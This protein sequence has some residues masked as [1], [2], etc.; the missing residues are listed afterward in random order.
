M[1]KYVFCCEIHWNLTKNH[2]HG[3]QA[4]VARDENISIQ[5]GVLNWYSDSVNILFLDSTVFSRYKISFS[6]REIEI[7]IAVKKKIPNNI[8]NNKTWT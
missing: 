6:W 5:T 8:K 3:F 4:V 7:Y 2:D 1:S